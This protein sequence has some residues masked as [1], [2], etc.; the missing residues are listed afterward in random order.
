M[1]LIFPPY[2]QPSRSDLGFALVGRSFETLAGQT[3]YENAVKN[4]IT[5]KLNMPD[6]TF[7]LTPQQQGR[8]AIG[9]ESEGAV[10][11][12]DLGWLRPMVSF[13]SFFI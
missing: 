13:P 9:Y 8:V 5:S 6:T 10:T 3:T 7:T 12:Y 1:S 11:N 4:Y 2:L